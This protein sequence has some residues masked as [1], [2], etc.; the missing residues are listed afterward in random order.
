VHILDSYGRW[1]KTIPLEG[2]ESLDDLEAVTRDDAGR[3]YFITSHSRTRKGKIRDSRRLLVRARVEGRERHR[4]VV[5][6]AVPWVDRVLQTAGKRNK[7]AEKATPLPSWMAFLA[8][9]EKSGEIDIEAMT[10]KGDTLLIGFKAPLREGKAVVLSISGLNELMGEKAPLASS[11]GLW[12]EWALPEAGGGFPQG[13]SDMQ[14]Q[15]NDLFM[16]TRSRGEGGE[17]WQWTPGASQPERIRVFSDAAP[18]GLAFSK[19][20]LILAF[21]RGSEKPSRFLALDWKP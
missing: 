3:V 20:K 2:L 12:A 5:E 7:S 10:C 9:A 6:A 1:E 11:I 8:A 21:D 15:G 16:L 18:E 14:M 17:L 13:F 19:G 4:L